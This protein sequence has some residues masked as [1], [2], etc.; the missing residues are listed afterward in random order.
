MDE[1]YDSIEKCQYRYCHNYNINFMSSSPDSECF[2][3]SDDLRVNLWH[4]ENNIEAYNLVDLKP[5]NIEDLSEVITHLEYHP[6]RSDTFIF[7]SSKGY[8]SR[9]DLRVSS[10][11]NTFSQKFQIEEDPSKKHFFTDIINSI[12]RAKFSPTD[13]NY[14]FS[15]NYLSV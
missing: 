3:S 2:I 15:R 5:N 1:G 4:A 11:Y 7:S 9:C 13:D 10:Q 12:S 14:I 8:F 6:K